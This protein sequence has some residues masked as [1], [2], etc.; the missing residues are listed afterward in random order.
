[1]SGIVFV[2]VH[3]YD[4]PAIGGW[5]LHDSQRLSSPITDH[6]GL[7]SQTS[8]RNESNLTGHFKERRSMTK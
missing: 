5:K 2:V 1:M 7:P 3:C 6:E 8:A 4:V